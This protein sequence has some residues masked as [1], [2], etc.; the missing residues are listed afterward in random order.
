MEIIM[1]RQKRSKCAAKASEYEYY[2]F[3]IEDWEPSYSF[4]LDGG[5]L[6]PGPYWEHVEI[7]LKG[8]FLAPARLRGRRATLPLMGD[9][10]DKRELDQVSNSDWKPLAVGS[11]EVRGDYTMYYG[12]VPYDALWGVLS[13]L[14][15]R[16]IGFLSLY[17]EKLRYGK[18]R[19]RSLDLCRE[20]DPDVYEGLDLS[21]PA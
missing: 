1:P 18:A 20:P 10:R 11:L 16:S 5:P 13:M 15:C 12:S 9:R 4:A 2:L 6:R 14:V 21:Q 19:I 8:V 7:R 3:K 17:G